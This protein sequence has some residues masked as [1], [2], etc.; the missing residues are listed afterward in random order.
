MKKEGTIGTAAFLTIAAVVGGSLQ[1]G[2]KQTTGGQAERE[3]PPKRSPL[4]S[5]RPTSAE[6]KPGCLSIEQQFQDF[7]NSDKA[8]APL[9]CYETSLPPKTE[10]PKEITDRTS[11]LRF[12]IATLP[13]PLHTHQAVLFDQFA[14]AI[15]DAAQDD[16]YD[17]DS[18]WLQPGSHCEKD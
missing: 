4:T 6:L 3:A 10:I 5:T 9:G 11:K 1:F 14:A 2:S 7:L 13:D 8:I 16:H 17:F 15:Q 12:V 18:S